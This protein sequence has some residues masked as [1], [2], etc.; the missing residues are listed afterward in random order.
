[1]LAGRGSNRQMTLKL[2][3][4]GRY[5][6]LVQKGQYSMFWSICEMSVNGVPGRRGERVPNDQLRLT[7][8][9]NAG[10]LAKMLDGNRNTRWDSGT[11]QRVGQWLTIELPK[12]MEVRRIVMDANSSRNDFPSAY[13]VDV[14]DDGKTWRGPLCVRPGRRR[15]HDGAAVAVQG[16]VRQDHA[17]RGCESLLL[18]H[19]RAVSLRRVAQRAR[20]RGRRR[21]RGRFLSL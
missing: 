16:Q 15:H 10:A 9:H 20:P 7:A 21:P 17:D 5:I 3:A 8:S 19:P 14:S 1:M 13:R 11:A 6:K 18:V 4:F 2:D 12:P